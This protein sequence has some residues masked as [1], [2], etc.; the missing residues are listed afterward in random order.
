M[1]NARSHEEIKAANEEYVRFTLLANASQASR[2]SFTQ[3]ANRLGITEEK[4]TYTI[5]EYKNLPGPS[6]LSRDSSTERADNISVVNTEEAIQS[7]EDLSI[8]PLRR[9]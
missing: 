3:I 8:P 5:Q 7:E 4:L 6:E 1:S 2:S 9:S